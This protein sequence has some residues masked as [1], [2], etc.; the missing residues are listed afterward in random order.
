MLPVLDRLGF[1]LDALL[2]SAGLRREDVASDAYIAPAA[3]VSV[4]TRAHQERRV[5]NLALQLAVHTPVGT[6]PLLDYLIVSADSVGHGLD[7]LVR[8]LRLVNP[9]IRIA[10]RAEGDPVRVEIERSS[11]WFENE[12]TVSLSVLRF[13][14]ETDDQ[15]QP[16][17]VAFTHEPDDVGEYA[18]V[19][20]CPVRV[21]AGWNGWALSQAAMSLPLRRRDPALGRWLERQ[22]A[23]IL[24][25][26]PTGG[27]ICDEVRRAL[28]TQLTA[29]DI[30]VDVVARR[31]ATTARTLQRRLAEAGT[32]FE[33]LR[34]D[35][36]KAAAE[37]FLGDPT[38]SIAE[39]A[40]LLGYSEPRAFHRAFR[41]WHG[42]TPHAFRAERG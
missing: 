31:L 5:S 30:R 18:R 13:R 15:L 33:A 24:A 3:C 2:A 29:G 9:G 35:A 34:D 14:R 37:I 4:F 23:D 12:L 19:L 25:R 22:A 20:R 11:G 8:Y 17:Q 1:D 28:S 39:V 42:T 10:I 6:T 7:R 40:Y 38:L 36:R 27:D 26:L 32:S 41:R 16:L 21:K